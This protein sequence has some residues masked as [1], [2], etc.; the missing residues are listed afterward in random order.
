[1]VWCLTINVN[2]FT[3]MVKVTF[4]RYCEVSLNKNLSA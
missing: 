1:M 4:F 3:L 2:L